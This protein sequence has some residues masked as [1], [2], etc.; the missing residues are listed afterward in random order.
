MLFL[1]LVLEMFIPAFPFV[2]TMIQSYLIIDLMVPAGME[3]IYQPGAAAGWYY[4]D[5]RQMLVFSF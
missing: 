1:L 3:V 4:A 2:I 5:K